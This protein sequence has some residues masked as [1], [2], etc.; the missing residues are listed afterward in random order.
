MKIIQMV[1]AILLMSSLIYILSLFSGDN[2]SP[3]FQK[4]KNF[5]NNQKDSAIIKF[6]LTSDEVQRINFLYS[7]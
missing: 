1:V 6:N 2:N 5:I 3:N 7:K 4:A